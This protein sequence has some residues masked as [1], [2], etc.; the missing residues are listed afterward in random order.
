MSITYEE[1]LG[2]LTA[3]FT[4]PWTEDSLDTVLRHFEGH[5]EN[6]VDAV[7]SHG[8]A[9][10]D[11]LI[12]RL[13]S[14][15]TGATISDMDAQLAKQLADQESQRQQRMSS[16]TTSNSNNMYMNQTRMAPPMAAPAPTPAPAPAPAQ[17]GRGTPTNLP[18]D[19]LRIP[20]AMSST[21][22]TDI[23]ND[24]AL[25]RMLQD[26][27]F[28]EE[29]KNNPE[30]AHLANGG[31]GA[32]GRRVVHRN[33]RR[34]GDGQPPEVLKALAGMG[35]QAKKRFQDLATNFKK[36]INEHQNNRNLQ[37]N[38]SFASGRV[39]GGGASETRGLL[40]IHDDDDEQE[41]SFVGS[42][43]RPGSGAGTHEMR[44]MD[45]GFAFNKKID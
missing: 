15:Q 23:A 3:M 21:S 30:F 22:N 1:A 33:G 17:K 29:L 42:G 43:G 5:M 31:A 7:L 25:A 2:T 36:K 44:S 9:S 28:A 27:L 24:E 39:G 13:E 8:D 45:T 4:N 41:I 20:S 10:P 11:D 38:G 35:E 32:G 34:P 37:S 14:S 12:R 19:F 6:T 18:P 16:T 26:K 40:D